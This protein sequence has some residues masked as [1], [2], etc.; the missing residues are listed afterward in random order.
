ML[1]ASS[2]TCQF[3]VFAA[4]RGDVFGLRR[5]YLLTLAMGTFFVLGQANEY[6]TLVHE[7]GTT[8]ASAPTAPSS[9]WPPAS[10][11]CTSPAGWSRSSTC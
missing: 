2:F 9:T 6:R 4:E 1:V 11:A 7:H 10:T 8:L 3:G 5:W